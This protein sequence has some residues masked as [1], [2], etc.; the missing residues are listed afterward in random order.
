MK[1]RLPETKNEI[2]LKLDWSGLAGDAGAFIVDVVSHGQASG[3][4]YACQMGVTEVVWIV[5]GCEMIH[6]HMALEF[7]RYPWCKV[8][9]QM[10]TWKGDLGGES[11]VWW[12]G[13]TVQ[14]GDSFVEQS[15]WVIV[16]VE[17]ACKWRWT[18]V[19]LLIDLF[20]GLIDLNKHV[21]IIN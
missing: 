15:P 12:I 19:P 5:G 4:V 13:M 1:G 21:F 16:R 6:V 9:L 2:R 8:Q 7:G 10:C 20:M 14:D 11:L 17:R 3:R 18:W